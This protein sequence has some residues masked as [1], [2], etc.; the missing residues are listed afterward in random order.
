MSLKSNVATVLM[1]ALALAGCGGG[2][3]SSTSSTD[4]APA[5]TG[6][7]AVAST[8]V[9]ST[10]V[11][12]TS[13]A[14][15][16]AVQPQGVMSFNDNG[17]LSTSQATDAVASDA[18]A[19]GTEHRAHALEV[20]TPTTTL[21]YNFDGSF[22]TLSPG[23]WINWWGSA[24]PT[25]T[26]SRET[27]TGYVLAGAASQRYRLNSVPSGGGAHLVYSY[28]F[29][30]N[31]AYSISLNVRSDVSTQ[32]LVQFRR[33]G[34][35]YNVVSSKTVTVG[36]AWQRV[37]LQGT[38]PFA[39][40]GTVRVIPLTYGT[41]IF[42]DE[43]TINNT[44]ASA[45]PPGSTQSPGAINLPAQGTTG[46][47]LTTV[48]NSNMDDAFTRFALGWYYNAYGGTGAQSFLAARE[49]RPDHVHAGASSQLFQ[50]SDKKGGDVQLTESYP[51]VKGNTYHAT[52]YM[53]AD[54]PTPVQVFIRVDASPWTVVATKTVT[55]NSTWQKI[56]LEG[57]YPS[58]AS[59]S[60]R[61][62]VLNPTGTFWIDDVTLSTVNKNDMAPWSTATLPDSLFG[63]HVNQLGY[64][65][66]W[67]GL[68]T[69]VLRLWNTGTNWLDL[70][71]AQGA[72]D[73]TTGGGKRLD[74]YV[75][76]AMT[77]NPNGEILYTLGQTPQW[78][79]STP[80]VQGL[81]GMGSSGAP[82]NMDDWRDYV[83]TLANR[84]KGRIRFWELWNEPDYAGTFTGSMS[85]LAQMAVIAKQELIAADPNNKL[86]GPG[87]TTGQGMNA[88]NGFLAAG[89][90]ASIDMV[91]YHWYYSINPESIGPSIDNVRGLMKTY[92]I[93]NKPIWNTE[94][95]FICDSASMDCKTAVPTP[96][97]SRGAN[98]RALFLMATKGIANFSYSFWETQSPF[99]KLVM[100][101]Y[102][103]ATDEAK[104]LAEGRSWAKG[105][106]IT[107]GYRVND[108]AY[109]FL[110]NRGSDN[111]VVLWAT[112]DNTL[113]NLPSQWNVTKVRTLSGT[114]SAIPS[115]RQIKLGIEPVMLKL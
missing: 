77:N 9:T 52:A 40:A 83:R 47:S 65:F 113:V 66:N 57:A 56:D 19:S 5:D 14:D 53:K 95:A 39:D 38:Y 28:G 49:T 76:Y 31:N 23:W 18:L 100:P 30:Q 97:Q 55:L 50:I 70:E 7:Q 27:R 98:V 112:K 92:G 79:S 110:M 2:S 103:T 109:V 96:A 3:G 90:G 16:A 81:Y 4:A 82:T 106:R 54:V 64:H 42:L 80:T 101:D 1:T 59:G 15:Q 8:P 72:W 78:A 115:N 69:N 46:S 25:F 32:V 12:A 13:A 29:V 74:M 26:A 34:S 105:A 20:A 84:Y 85:T 89:G 36:P 37:D 91:G 51:F 94:G 87:F 21:N 17:A 33:A 44:T 43:M 111:F 41:D 10:T 22:T 6:S 88:M 86:V 107:G 63:M 108:Q 68:N 45:P 62:A 99:G 114:E 67:P 35:P 60:F 71:K 48:L 93:E 58:D 61:V 73:F 102:L 75:N 24:P 11:A 104:A